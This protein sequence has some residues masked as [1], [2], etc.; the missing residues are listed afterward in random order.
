MSLTQ[1]SQHAAAEARLDIIP[2]PPPAVTVRMV[3]PTVRNRRVDAR[4]NGIDNGS[5]DHLAD[6]LQKKQPSSQSDWVSPQNLRHLEG[7]Q[8]NP[9]RSFRHGRNSSTTQFGPG[10]KHETASISG[11]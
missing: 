11:G 8:T 6:A 5:S 7:Q 3:C 1:V 4:P 10:S 9:D 2:G